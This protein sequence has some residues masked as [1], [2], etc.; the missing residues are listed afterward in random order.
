MKAGTHTPHTHIHAR[1]API[2]RDMQQI[3]APL[4]ANVLIIDESRTFLHLAAPTASSAPR[5]S[6]SYTAVGYLSDSHDVQRPPL[7]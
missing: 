4:P 2:F 6:F 5:G 3:Q 7:G 1:W